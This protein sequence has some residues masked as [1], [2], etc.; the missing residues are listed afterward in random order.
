M[1]SCLSECEAVGGMSWAAVSITHAWMG[2]RLG[3]LR[4]GYLIVWLKLE[5]CEAGYG[6][7]F[8][9]TRYEWSKDNGA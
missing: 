1:A 6:G 5:T 4:V 7:L 8:K 2:D 9:K 3:H